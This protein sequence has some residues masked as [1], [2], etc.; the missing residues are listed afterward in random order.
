MKAAGLTHGGFYVN[1]K[2]K[3]DLA[4]QACERALETSRQ[5]MGALAG[6]ASGDP[7]SEMV[8]Y[9]VSARHR[10]DPG[11]GCAF[12]ALAPDAA[13]QE[14]AVRSVFTEG[15]RSYLDM[16]AQA[17]PGR[18]AAQ[19]RRQAMSALSQMVGAVVLAR[20][21]DDP[22]LSDE[23][24][25]ATLANLGAASSKRAAPTRVRSAREPA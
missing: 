25:Y 15:L 9:Y 10:D 11:A 23:I 16:L 13:R 2:S 6:S 22:A 14:S 5:R 3:E 19:R 7:L 1:F 21:G 17:M 20:A 12:A 24:L 18:T 8:R 4:A